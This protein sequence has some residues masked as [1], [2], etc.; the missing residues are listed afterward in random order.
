MLFLRNRLSPI[1]LG[2]IC[3]TA[4]ILSAC[5]GGNHEP[6]MA[7]ISRQP[8]KLSDSVD[9]LW[10]EQVNM[11]VAEIVGLSDGIVHD[12][13][14]LAADPLDSH[15]TVA[16][17]DYQS[18]ET[19]KAIPACQE[20]VKTYPNENRFKY[21]LARAQAKAGKM[22]E[23]IPLLE[24]LSQKSY[25]PA[26]EA[27]GSIFLAKGRAGGL[28]LEPAVALIQTAAEAGNPNSQWMLGGFNLAGKIKE[29]NVEEG[30]QWLTQAAETGHP[31]AR[32]AL[33]RLYLSGIKD[34]MDPD[35]KKSVHY[36]RQAAAQ[37]EPEANYLLALLNL[38]GH[39][40]E[41]NMNRYFA[42]L[43]ES[44]RMGN[45]LAQ[46]SLAAEYMGHGPYQPEKG[47]AFFW[48]IQAMK[49]RVPIAI[50]MMADLRETLS[51]Q[52][53]GAIYRT[54]KSWSPPQKPVFP[55]TGAT[56]AIDSPEAKEAEAALKAAEQDILN[57][58]PPSLSPVAY[59]GGLPGSEEEEDDLIGYTLPED[60][61]LVPESAL[62]ASE[63]SQ[64]TSQ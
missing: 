38:R 19:A 39:G 23:A 37:S 59:F 33:G 43:Q 17:I 7:Q 30:L 28:N 34:Q 6:L 31:R 11:K 15:K 47:K 45:P 42:L 63:G 22:D 53:I 16:G 56:V 51:A 18:I 64:N 58:P 48:L 20:A 41:K 21:Q 35:L 50:A 1:R 52:E 3:I 8:F 14:K 4:L 49:S 46:T 13:D 36:L 5:A 62:K 26:Q 55:E 25:S 12:C 29:R 32:S 44:A 57:N 61:Q 10:R 9:K 40:V 27:L 2:L 60:V 54:A 24:S